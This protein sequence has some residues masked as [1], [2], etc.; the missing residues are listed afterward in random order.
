M[1]SRIH[2]RKCRTRAERIACM[3]SFEMLGYYSDVP[4]SQRYPLPFMSWFY[5]DCGSFIALAGNS[6]SRHVVRKLGGRLMEAGDIPVEC[7]A[8]PL[9]PGASLSDNW[10][11]WKEGYS[12]LMITDTAFFRN[13]HYHMPSDLPETLNYTRMA[14]LVRALGK[15]LGKLAFLPSPLFLRLQ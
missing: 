13:P 11:F 3:I 12:A 2:A 5:P 9:L 15:A 6:R 14:G 8:F 1:G 7:A 4:G 10:S